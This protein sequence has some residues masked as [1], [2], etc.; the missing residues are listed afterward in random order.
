[1]RGTVGAYYALDTG[2]PLK[3]GDHCIAYQLYALCTVLA[4]EVF[5]DARR[6]NPVHHSIRHF[7]NGDLA[8]QLPRRGGCFESNV[9]A[10]DNHDLRSRLHGSLYCWHIRDGS[11]IVHASQVRPRTGQVPGDCSKTQKQ[12]IVDDLV[13]VREVDASGARV[14]SRCSRAKFKLDL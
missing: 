12:A 8:A 3:A 13:A 6:G 7:Q 1:M 14:N 4:R 11:K 10:S 5:R 2:V 9:A